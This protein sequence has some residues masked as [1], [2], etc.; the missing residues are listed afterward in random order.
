MYLIL[1]IKL[2]FIIGAWISGPFLFASESNYDQGWYELLRYR[3]SFFGGYKSEQ[4]FDRFFLTKEGKNNPDAEWSEFINQARVSP[5]TSDHII[6]HFPARFLYAKKR[7]ISNLPTINLLSKCR[8][9]QNFK[10]KLRPKAV[11]L[12]FSSYYMNSAASAFGHTLMR[13]SKRGFEQSNRSFELLDTGLNYSATVTTQNPILYGIFG[14]VGGFTGEFLSLPYFYKVREYNDHESR[15]LWIYELNLTDEQLEFLIAHTWEMSRAKF[16]YY[17]FTE[18]CSYHLLG[19]LNAVNPKWNL[20]NKTNTFII[21]IDTIKVLKETPGLIKDIHYRPSSYKRFKAAEK[22]LSKDELKKLQ[23]GIS[24]NFKYKLNDYDKNSRAKILDAALSFLDYKHSED[25]LRE[26]GEK[27]KSKQNLLIQRANL[28]ISTELPKPIFNKEEG[29]QASHNSG[30]IELIG[31]DSQLFGKN[32]QLNYRFSFHDYLDNHI[33]QIK[34]SRIEM[35]KFK[36]RFFD[37]ELRDKKFFLEELYFVRVK[38]LPPINFY[39]RSMSFKIEA[40][41][42]RDLNADNECEY[43]SIYHLEFSPGVAFNL[44][45]DFYLYSLLKVDAQ[46]VPNLSKNHA[47]LIWGNESGLIFTK[48]ESFKFELSYQRLNGEFSNYISQD[49]FAFDTQFNIGIKAAMKLKLEKRR[50]EEKASVSIM[51]YF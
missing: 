7:N 6:C 42:K 17:Y 36:A 24:E 2:F 43:C 11:S 29:P 10:D 34:T 49:V 44:G 50:L 5:V 1:N 23:E 4:D 8:D 22:I 45:L 9:F 46:Y 41:M 28:G 40:G 35:G 25:I 30:K 47:R 48:Y 39:E 27:Y 20:I 51:R 3:K 12:E 21:P 19:L 31:E 38:S 33:G 37:S 18:N 13:F 15:D 26:S 32:I 14:I 16:T